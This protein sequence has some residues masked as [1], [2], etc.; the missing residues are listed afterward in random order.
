MKNLKL[1][2][3]TTGI[4][5]IT[6]YFLFFRKKHKNIKPMSNELYKLIPSENGLQNFIPPDETNI[7]FALKKIASEFGLNIA[8]LVE[9]MY[10]LETNHFNSTVFKKTNG[11]GVIVTPFNEK[12]FKHRDKLRIFVK[13]LYQNGKF[14]KNIVVPENTP[15]AKQYTYV[16]FPTIYDGMRYLAIYIQKYKDN[17]PER[18]SAGAYNIEKLNK[19]NTKYV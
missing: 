14:L 4:V 17:A 15:N 2:L 7:I 16:I 9:K 10:R 8:Q 12:F 13:P 19:L 1:Y 3:F 18:W 5:L 11:A 6:I